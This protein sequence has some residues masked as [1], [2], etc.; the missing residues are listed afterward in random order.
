MSAKK[1]EIENYDKFIEF[2][3]KLPPKRPPV[4]FFFSGKKKDNGHSWC[5]YCQLGM[6]IYLLLL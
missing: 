6:I 4:Y 3:D 5:I 1:E 2:I